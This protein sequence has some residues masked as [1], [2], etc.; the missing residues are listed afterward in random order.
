MA[1][2]SSASS[3]REKLVS[4]KAEDILGKPLTKRQKADLERLRNLPD[5]Q[6]DFSDIPELTDEQLAE[7]RRPRKPK[8][9]IAARLDVDVVAW[10]KTLGLGESGY[11][12]HINK[13]L[14]AVMEASSPAVRTLPRPHRRSA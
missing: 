2:K 1:K 10:L 7:M 9:L 11:S 3:P 13:I 4:Y 14:R 8:K 5:S 12:S 6:I